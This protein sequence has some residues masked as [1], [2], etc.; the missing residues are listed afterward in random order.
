MKKIPK[1]EDPVVELIWQR[2]DAEG[3]SADQSASAAS[4][5]R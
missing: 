3:I 5:R 2:A 4:L 1:V